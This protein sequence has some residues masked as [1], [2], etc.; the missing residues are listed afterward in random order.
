MRFQPDDLG[1]EVIAFLTERHLGTLSLV[2]PEG[3]LHVSPVGITWDDETGIARVI[4][5]ASSKKVRIIE[6]AGT[7]SAVVSQVDGGRW[8]ALHG[9]ATVSSDPQVNADAERRYAARYRPPGDRGADR[10]TIEIVVTKMLG[11][12]PTSGH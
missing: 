7:V 5:F 12:V 3:D 9:M 11:R 4:T 6:A 2:T 10:R 1:P 8:L